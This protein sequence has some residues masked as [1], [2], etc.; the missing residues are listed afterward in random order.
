MHKKRNPDTF[1]MDELDL[2]EVEH[3]HIEGSMLGHSWKS[4]YIGSDVAFCFS[5]WIVLNY[6][7]LL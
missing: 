7:K 1:C 5:Y 6:W 2:K 4:T 3:L